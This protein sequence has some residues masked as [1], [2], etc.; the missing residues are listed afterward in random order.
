MIT[1]TLLSRLNLLVI[2]LIAGQ[3]SDLAVAA[4]RRECPSALS[5]GA[6]TRRLSLDSADQSTCKAL[7]QQRAHIPR[8]NGAWVDVRG[9]CQFTATLQQP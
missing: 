8:A 4:R 9:Y 1:A 6:P 7:A 3:A 2:V 5:P